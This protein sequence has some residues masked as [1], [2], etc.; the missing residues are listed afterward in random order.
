MPLLLVYPRTCVADRTWDYLTLFLHKTP[1]RALDRV[2][3]YAALLDAFIVS[4]PV[5]RPS[6][7]CSAFHKA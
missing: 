6:V 7:L 1:T 2:V 5:I 4:H 3:W